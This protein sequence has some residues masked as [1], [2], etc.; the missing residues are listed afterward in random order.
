MIAKTS[1]S[2]AFAATLLDSETFPSPSLCHEKILAV[3]VT[4]SSEMTL[5]L[6]SKMEYERTYQIPTGFTFYTENY[7]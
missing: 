4:I 2:H 3:I 6:R 1:S 5:I 7:T